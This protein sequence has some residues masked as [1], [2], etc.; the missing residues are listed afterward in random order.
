M[1]FIFELPFSNYMCVSNPRFNNPPVDFFTWVLISLG[2]SNIFEVGF[3]HMSR[4]QCKT[5]SRT[6]IYHNIQFR[7]VRL[8]KWTPDKNVIKNLKQRFIIHQIQN[9]DFIRCKHFSEWGKLAG[10]YLVFKS[11]KGLLVLP[12]LE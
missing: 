12:R 1:S 4:Q 7:A 11:V 8:K 6:V 3:F 10:F 2:L 9:I 5:F